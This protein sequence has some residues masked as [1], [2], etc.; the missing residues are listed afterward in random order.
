VNLKIFTEDF[1]K[2]GDIQYG[3]LKSGWKAIIAKG[4][5]I[6]PIDKLLFTGYHTVIAESKEIYYM[7][8]LVSGEME[9][10]DV[11]DKNYSKAV[12]WQMR[13][14]R[15]LKDTGNK[16]K[17]NV[18]MMGLLA[19]IAKMRIF[20][21]EICTDKID[22]PIIEDVY[23]NGYRYLMNG[24]HYLRYEF[25]GEIIGGIIESSSRPNKV[26]RFTYIDTS[27]DTEQEHIAEIYDDKVVKIKTD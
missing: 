21:S 18:E 27:K 23:L 13:M 20:F 24:K 7:I 9:T 25:N 11:N 8:D 3:K 19:K 15:K 1:G 10:A 5:V 2:V 14:C 16:D 22:M 17:Y 6:K 4:K 26:V 12:K